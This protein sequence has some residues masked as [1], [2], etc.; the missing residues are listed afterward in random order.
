MSKQPAIVATVAYSS[1]RRPWNRRVGLC[2]CCPCGV[3]AVENRNRF[4]S[5][6]LCHDHRLPSDEDAEMLHSALYATQQLQPAPKRAYRV[7]NG[8]G[9]GGRKR[10]GWGRREVKRRKLAMRYEA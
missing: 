5:P 4:P 2:N 3:V 10:A 8:C 6:G 9:D 1:G 7:E